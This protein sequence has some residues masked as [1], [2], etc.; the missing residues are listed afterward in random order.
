MTT[1]LR[2][3][4]RTR[5]HSPPRPAAPQRRGPRRPAP[6]SPGAPAPKAEWTTLT[7]REARRK[8]AVLA[9]GY[10][11]LGVGAASTSCMMMGNRPE[12]WLSDLA[13]VHLGAVPV[14]VYGTSAP[15]QIAH[16]AR[17][18][19]ARF[20]IVEGARGTGPLGA[21]ACRRPAS[22]GEPGR[23]RGGRRGPAPH[24][25]LPARHAAAR[26]A[27]TRTPS[28]GLARD[29]GR[30]S[31]DRGLHLGHHRRPEGRRASR[32]RN[33]VYQAVALDR[34]VDCPTTPRTSGLPAARPH[35]RADA[36]HLPARSTAPRT[37]TICADP[38]AARRRRCASCTRCS[39]SACP[40]VWEKLAAGVQAALAAA[41]RGAAGGDRGGERPA[42]A[43]VA[44]L[45]ARRGQAGADDWRP[46][47]R[48]PRTR[49][50]CDPMLRA[51]RLGP[52][53]WT[54]SGAAPM[55]VDVVRFW[56]GFGIDVMEAWGM[57]ETTGI[58]TINTPDGFRLGIGRAADRRHGAAASPTTA[59]SWCAARL[60]FGGYLRA[61]GG[62]EPACDAD[63]WLATGDI[64]AA[65]RG[66]LPLASPT[67]RRN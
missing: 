33:V 28:R 20:A 30:R 44:Y 36:R 6:P 25:R 45:R 15:E 37:C 55:P 51:G 22:L 4:G 3:P 53:V 13:L 9:A 27:P 56:A 24:L 39:S 19:R 1:I 5:R 52:L 16:I 42:R 47:C 61:D 65:R 62:V 46:G 21:A 66:R 67:A 17:H 59:R 2:L 38:H 64:G 48:R 29:P 7:W 57:T 14:T 26:A 32:H 12:H 31:A 10:A 35:R 43:R 63:G 58:A 41:A 34:V 50:C 60:V 23:R 40:R 11:A 8:V 54:A 49:R 18:S